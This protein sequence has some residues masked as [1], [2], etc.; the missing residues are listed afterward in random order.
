MSVTV[1]RNLAGIQNW[2]S[3][4]K[5]YGDWSPRNDCAEL[6]FKLND[7]PA[8]HTR[9]R[10]LPLVTFKQSRSERTA[11]PFGTSIGAWLQASA[12]PEGGDR[13]WSKRLPHQICESGF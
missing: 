13:V 1:S 8:N 2:T 11:P 12:L 4:R 5:R 3:M 9:W 6:N 7:S 10:C